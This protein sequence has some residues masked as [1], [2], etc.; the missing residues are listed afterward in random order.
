MTLQKPNP[1]F[2]CG[3]THVFTNEAEAD[4]DSGIGYFVGCFDCDIETAVCITKEAAI[5]KWNYRPAPKWMDR[6]DDEGEYWVISGCSRGRLIVEVKRDYDLCE[7][8]DDD[9]DF[10]DL[11]DDCDD[12]LVVEHRGNPRRLQLQ[13]YID[14]FN[15]TGFCKIEMPDLPD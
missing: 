1:C 14:T 8:Y 11:Y 13:D 2:R 5:E 6:P 9:D 15:V 4:T 10:C 3:S 12:C 7:G